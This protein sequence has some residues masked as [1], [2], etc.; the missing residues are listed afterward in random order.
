MVKKSLSDLLREEV[1]SEEPLPL[2]ETLTSKLPKTID[3]DIKTNFSEDKLKILR[4][5]LDQEQTKSAELQAQLIEH[6]QQVKTLLANLKKTEKLKI[7]LETEKH[8]VMTLESQI[9]DIKI[10]LRTEKERVIS[11]TSEIER[12][13]L[14]DVYQH[15]ALAALP[16]R[17]V[18][19]SQPSTSLSNADIGWFD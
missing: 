15:H 9:A 1:R 2:P 16:K 18:A 4:H 19:P 5:Q 17:Y 10:S 11:L 12:L 14:A 7:N 13:T 8:R 6:Q 3:A